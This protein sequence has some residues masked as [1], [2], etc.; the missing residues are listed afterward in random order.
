MMKSNTHLLAKL[1]IIAVIQV[2]SMILATLKIEMRCLSP[3]DRNKARFVASDG[4]LLLYQQLY[5]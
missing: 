3:A 2:P 5:L 1:R 4:K